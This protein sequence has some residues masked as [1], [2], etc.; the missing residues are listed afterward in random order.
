MRVANPEINRIPENL[1]RRYSRIRRTKQLLRP[2]PRKATL[3]RYPVIKWFAAAAR[4]QPAL[5]S[6]RVKSVSPAIYAGCII[7]LLPI[8]GI[9]IPLACL[10]AFLFR[11]NLPVAAALQLI[12]NPLTVIFIYPFNYLVGKAMIDFWGLGQVD[13]MIGAKAYSLALGGIIVGLVI[14]LI[15]DLSY[16]LGSKAKKRRHIDLKRMLKK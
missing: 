6:F 12:T 10:A 14:A 2:L 3:H 7:A 15:L 5:W 9:Q 13:S 1:Q 16:R 8:Y 4:K 11:M